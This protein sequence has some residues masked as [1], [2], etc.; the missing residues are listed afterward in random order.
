MK[1]FLIASLTLFGMLVDAAVIGSSL[2][3]LEMVS[4]S[5]NNGNH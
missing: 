1:I 5:I 2:N 3:E 4:S